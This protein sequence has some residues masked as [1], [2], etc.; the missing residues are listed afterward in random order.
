[1]IRR[2]KGGHHRYR[3]NDQVPEQREANE[4]LPFP[5]EAN[6]TSLAHSPFAGFEQ[7]L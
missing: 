5:S 1:M 7:D 4:A 3:S 6:D 2:N